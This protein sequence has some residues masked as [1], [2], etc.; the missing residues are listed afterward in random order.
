[1]PE[2]EAGAWRSA[3][4]QRHRLDTAYLD[5]ASAWFDPLAATLAGYQRG[6]ARPVLFAFNGCQGSGKTTLCDYLCTALIE[7]YALNALALSLDDFYL[8]HAER[9]QLA[10]TV[11][12]L[13]ATRGVPGTHDMGLLLETLGRLLH[14]PGDGPVAIPRFDKAADDRC[15]REDWAVATDPVQVVLLEGW[16]LGA[17]TEPGDS[18][19]VPINTLEREEDPDGRWRAHVDAVLDTEF[20][21]LYGLV[22][23]WIMLQAP[24]FDCVYAWRREQERKLAATVPRD[25]AGRLM[26]DAAL[27]RFIQHYE[28]LTRQCLEHLP[29]KVHHLFTLDHA[30]R[31]TGY[32]HNPSPPRSP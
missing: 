27:E 16:C 4:L 19:A 5:T 14:W 11:H 31:I 28:R 32:R 6:Q 24:S 2:R 18:I 15:S 10:S 21:A 8:T 9:R 22:D 13:L 3:L 29:Q 26:D 1:M 12:P 23:Q 20:P 17:G 7:D 25:R 30:R